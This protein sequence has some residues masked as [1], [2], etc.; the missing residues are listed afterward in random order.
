M[1]LAFAAAAAVCSFMNS[2]LVLIAPSGGEPLADGIVAAVRGSLNGQ[3]A[4]ATRW[5]SPGRACEIPFAGVAPAKAAGAARR[6]L[7]GRR[8]DCAA[9]PAEGR[10]KKLLVA[11]MDSTIVAGEMLDDLADFAGLKERVAAITARA[12]NGEIEYKDSL[13]ARVALLEGLGAECLEK[14]F[15]RARLNPGAATLVATMRAHG[16]HTFLVSSGFRYFTSRVRALAGFD[17]DI[18]NEV[19]I[20]DGK[21]TGRVI[22]PI[23]DK[24]A[25]RNALLD[26]AARLKLAPSAAVAVGDGANDLPMILEAGL[27]VAY[28]PKPSVAAQAPVVVGH[29]DLTAL[30]YL[31]GYADDE[32]AG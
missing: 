13:R 29:A 30:L 3:D 16:A 11:D 19:E 17:A 23:L 31:Q 26:A 25:K 28:H 1:L 18:G 4:G 24:D 7:G 14:T 10:R 15:A 8:I 21:L 27:G 2:V 22:E 32:F 9:L 12:M 20:A 5:L 6:A